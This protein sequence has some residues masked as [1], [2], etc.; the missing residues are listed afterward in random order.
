ML[1]ASQRVKGSRYRELEATHFIP[2]EYPQIVL[3]ELHLLLA[4]V[5]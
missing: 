1:T 4:R 2:V 3:D 5:G